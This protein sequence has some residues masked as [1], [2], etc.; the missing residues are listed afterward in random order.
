M[1]IAVVQ[2]TSVV[3]TTGTTT[4][5][6]VTS[7]GSGN[8]LAIT[9]VGEGASGAQTITS[10]T[11]NQSNTW[12]LA[13]GTRGT[14]GGTFFDSE[15]W[16]VANATAGVTSLTVTI[17][18][19]VSSGDCVIGF[20]EISGAKT[21]SPLEGS[22]EADTTISGPTAPTGPA[23]TTASTGSILLA[24]CFPTSSGA[25]GVSSPWTAFSSALKFNA[26]YIPGAAS[27]YTALWQPTTAQQWVSSGVSFLPTA[28]GPSGA[29]KASTF[30]VL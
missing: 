18:N 2:S 29:Q 17:A 10:I 5:V 6:T 21:S 22:F 24:T 15:I 7:T 1:S 26:Y 20:I 14:I 13:P 8:L 23:V 12:I 28:S 4:S 25:T 11:D 19:S 9:F 30:L 3:N 27:T 16:Y